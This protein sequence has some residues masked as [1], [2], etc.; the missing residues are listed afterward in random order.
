MVGL[1]IMFGLILL[2]KFETIHGQK[3]HVIHCHLKHFFFFFFF[4]GRKFEI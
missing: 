2:T 4:L 1:F 3:A